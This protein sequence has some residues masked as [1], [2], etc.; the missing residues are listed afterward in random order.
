MRPMSRRCCWRS[1]AIK[2]ADAAFVCS[3]EDRRYLQRIGMARGVEVVPNGLPVPL[4]PAPRCPDPT[5]LF[6]GTYGY[7]PNSDAAHRLIT[8]IF[9]LIRRQVPEAR[10]IIA[11]VLP[12]R[13]ASFRSAPP[14]VEFTGFVPDLAALYAESRVVACPM[15]VGGGTRIK[16]V[17]AASYGRPMVSTRIGAEG[18]AFDDGREI[19]LRDDD[20]DFAAACVELLLD[21]AACAR[22]GLAARAKMQVT[23]AAEAIVDCIVDLMTRR[24]G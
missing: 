20:A 7:K 17:E 18:L 19:V 12:E 1:A 16:L 3:E 15:I 2:L 23:Y 10:L 24:R 6:L 14:G 9:P 8:Q 13:I 4:S 5:V 11:V 21:D 22:L